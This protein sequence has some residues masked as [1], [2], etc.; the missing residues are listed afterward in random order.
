M[1]TDAEALQSA[2][3]ARLCALVADLLT[4]SMNARCPHGCLGLATARDGCNV[5]RC[6]TCRSFFCF[7]CGESLA[8]RT[9]GLSLTEHDWDGV[10]GIDADTDAAAHSVFFATHVP[11]GCWMFDSP[12]TGQTVGEL[13][14]RQAA[15]AVNRRVLEL[16]GDDASRRATVLDLVTPSLTHLHLAVDWGTMSVTAPPRDVVELLREANHHAD[17]GLPLAAA[18]DGL[19]ARLPLGGAADDGAAAWPDAMWEWQLRA[20]FDDADAGHA[21]GLDG[22]GDGGAGA[23]AAAALFQDVLELHELDVHLD[24]VDAANLA[25]HARME[26]E[27]A[28][29]DR[30]FRAIMADLD[31]LRVQLN[32]AI[33]MHHL[34][35]AGSGGEVGR[36]G[37]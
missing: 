27:D 28:D 6:P 9:T 21:G 10:D 16:L 23:G 3:T 18:D 35:V 29:L 15:A 4:E 20:L 33:H 24:A 7:V 8:E 31:N 22:A 11:R 14:R 36:G 30:Q 37:S 5:V 2:P 26:R 1:L 13:R 12:Q 25:R 32:A 34:L 17:G 19:A